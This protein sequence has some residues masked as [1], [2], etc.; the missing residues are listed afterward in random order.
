MAEWILLGGMAI[1]TVVLIAIIWSARRACDGSSLLF[2]SRTTELKEGLDRLDRNS[3]EEM[4][5]NRSEVAD[6]LA[7]STATLSTSI[8]TLTQGQ[9][10]ELESFARQ[11]AQQADANERRLENL[12]QTVEE[13][14]RILSEENSRKLE[15][16]RQTVDEKLQTTL[17]QRLGE[18]FKQV[19]DRLEVVHRGL[20]E[21]QHLA[22]GVGD[23]KKVLTNVKTR[24]T[25]AE[26]QLGALLEQML[27]CDQFLKNVE[28]R[29]GS[30][31][32]VEFA[33]KF[34]GR[35]G[36]A[37]GVLM[38]IDAK[39]P[40]EDYQR[41]IEAQEKT[42]AMAAEAAAKKLEDCIKAAAKKIRDSYL[43]PPA[44]TDFAIMYL[45]TE[46]L[47]AE[48]LRRT[49]LFEALQRDYRVTPAGPTT[50]SAILNSLQMGFRT[51]AIQKRAGEVW[52][53]LGA[54]KTEFGKF[55]EL[56]EGVRKKLDE[57]QHKIEDATRKSKTIERKLLGVET[58]SLP[59][60]AVPIA[61][62]SVLPAQPSLIE[63]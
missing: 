14:L 61:T 3:R 28:T 21:M 35:D 38:P 41:L 48:V 7:R 62:T 18:S 26:I 5:R 43:D 58:V 27:P 37:A 52:Q 33:V 11:L 47:Y 17:E 29:A 23:L 59:A 36:Q 54:V 34:P 56:L 4:A 57:A 24:G 9:K 60:D 39:F 15:Q 32:R 25:L 45:G 16:M 55:G 20:G 46:G 40:L 49:G 10:S 63:N 19:S 30:N 12:R 53:V 8:S 51:L 44:T 22:V 6:S 42:D 50:L 2:Q 31:L 13:R 1:Q